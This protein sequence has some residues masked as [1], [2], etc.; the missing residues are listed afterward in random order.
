MKLL[1]QALANVP[2]EIAT[3]MA[4]EYADLRTRLARA[5]YSPANLN[6]GRFA[7]ALARYLEYKSTGAYTPIG[8]QLNRNVVLTGVRANTALPGS[9]RAHLPRVTEL[10]MDV[11]NKR[12]IAHLGKDVDVAEM[13]SELV[14]QLAGWAL[15]E[16]V[17]VEAAIAPG[18]CQGLVDMLCERRV[19]LVEE[20]NGQK[21]VVAPELTASERVLVALYDAYPAYQTV[22]ALLRS[23]RYA[24]PTRFRKLLGDLDSR[25][26]VVVAEHG[27]HLTSR[28]LAHVEA[29][30][31]G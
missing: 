30:L 3:L 27:A 17:R 14:V 12:D 20:F 5:D 1:S 24:N 18:E 7:E 11:R 16:V 31:L 28:G 29:E 10:L 9:L 13:D 26:L 6:G 15:A 4:N 21:I 19:P 22:P 8:T 25:G 2:K 23:V